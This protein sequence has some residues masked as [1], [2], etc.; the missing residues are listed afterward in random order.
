[1]V[2]VR[3]LPCVNNRMGPEAENTLVQLR[4]K[5]VEMVGQMSGKMMLTISLP[6]PHPSNFADSIK[7]MG[8]RLIAPVNRSIFEP[9]PVHTQ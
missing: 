7:E 8:M 1:M 3:Y 4:I 6:K 5:R 9:K 2:V